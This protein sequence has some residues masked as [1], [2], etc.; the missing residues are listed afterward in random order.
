MGNSVNDYRC[1]IGTFLN[2]RS[3][4]KVRKC[5]HEARN[6]NSGYLIIR[7]VFLLILS[8]LINQT[9]QDNPI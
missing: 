3:R 2:N 8:L 1:R 9:A 4:I 7:P 5:K 6:S